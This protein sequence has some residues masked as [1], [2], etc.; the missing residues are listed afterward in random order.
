MRDCVVH[1]ELIGPDP[2]AGVAQDRA[3]EDSDVAGSFGRYRFVNNT[4]IQRNS[5][6]RSQIFAHFGVES[7]EMHNKVFHIASHTSRLVACRVPGPPEPV[8]P[9]S[10]SHIIAVDSGPARYYFTHSGLA[11]FHHVAA[12]EM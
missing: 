12:S 3:R 8:A 4:F 2:D 5:D 10:Y 11:I 7:V 6:P 9:S 1:L